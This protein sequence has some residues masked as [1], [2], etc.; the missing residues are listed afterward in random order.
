M[1]RAL[2]CFAVPREPGR[3]CE[4]AW[5]STLPDA[6]TANH[7]AHRTMVRAFFFLFFFLFFLFLFF[8]FF[9]FF[10]PMEWQCRANNDLPCRTYRDPRC[11][12][13]Q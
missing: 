3:P 8:L 4:V 6:D 13:L 12:E 11:E 5:V 1:E 9:L 10:F 2:L 7:P